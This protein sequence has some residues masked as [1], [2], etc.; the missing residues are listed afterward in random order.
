MQWKYP[1][2]SKGGSDDILGG[3][4]WGRASRLASVSY[5]FI[6][7]GSFAKSLACID[8][9]GPELGRHRHSQSGGVAAGG[10]CVHLYVLCQVPRERAQGRS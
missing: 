10:V 5:I 3:A 7:S 9:G 4:G 2:G 1:E 8:A 6:Q